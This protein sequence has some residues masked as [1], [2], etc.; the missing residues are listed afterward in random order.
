[1][2]RRSAVFI[3]HS[4]KLKFTA[5]RM[6]DEDSGSQSGERWQP[7]TLSTPD[8]KLAIHTRLP[9][10]SVQA[11]RWLNKSESAARGGCDNRFIA[12]GTNTGKENCH[13]P[14]GGHVADSP[15]SQDRTHPKKP[16]PRPRPP[17]PTKVRRLGSGIGRTRRSRRKPE[18]GLER[19]RS[20]TT[21]WQLRFGVLF[22]QTV[23][24][25]AFVQTRSR[26]ES[27]FG[28]G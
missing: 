13:S 20:A 27:A 21:D 18:S 15:M 5:R 22:S 2:V 16:R 26:S 9:N 7:S 6:P 1:M 12:L 24:P 8:R 14:G 17:C 11:G 4:E 28:T 25:E 10:R 23:Q 3:P 19:G